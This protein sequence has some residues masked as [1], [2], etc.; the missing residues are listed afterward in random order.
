MELIGKILATDNREELR[1]LADEYFQNIK[2]CGE[3]SSSPQADQ[4]VVKEG[5]WA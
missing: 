4:G 5:Q 2:T 3:I 1:R